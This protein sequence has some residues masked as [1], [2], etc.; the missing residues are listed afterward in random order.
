VVMV[1]GWHFAAVM[2]CFFTWDAAARLAALEV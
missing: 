2:L 1:P